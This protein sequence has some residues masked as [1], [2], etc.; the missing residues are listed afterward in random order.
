MKQ[1]LVLPLCAALLLGG[2]GQGRQD[3]GTARA[4]SVAQ[5]PP[6]E[7]AHPLAR[8]TVF[9]AHS[10]VFVEA[11]SLAVGEDARL[12]VHVTRLG[13]FSALGAAQVTLTLSGGGQP[14]EVF[15]PGDAPQPG[16]YPL[17]LRPAAG[18]LREL[19]IEV[20][21]ADFRERHTLGRI[22]VHSNHDA[23]AHDEDSHPEAGGE[24]I[25]FSK[26]RQW[27]SDFATIAVATRPLRTVLPATGTLRA[28]PDGEAWLTAPLAGQI[29]AGRN[30]PRLG[31][32]V[33]QGEIL[34]YLA[35]RLGGE[36]D[37]A[38]LRAALAR[39][40][41]EADLAERELARLEGLWADE[42]IP[43]KRVFAARAGAAAARA[44][45]EAAQARLGQYGGA[46]SGAPL[47][48]PVSGIIA[49][50]RSAPGAWAQE[51]A[52]LFHIADRRVLWLELRVAEADAARL[53]APDGAYFRIDGV[54][55]G[56]TVTPGK[57]ARLIAVGGAIDPLSRTLPVVFEF[58]A[59][60]ERLRI[61][62]AVKAEVFAGA[63]RAATAIP[64]TAVVDD[65]GAPTVYLMR[66]GEAFER[67][68]VRLG[69][70]AGEWVEVLD[71]L[72]PGQRVVA[73]GAWLVRLAAARGGDI[74]HGH[75]H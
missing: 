7:A 17:T 37:L 6:G 34:A 27:K 13:D 12:A 9:G 38:S 40:R 16:I 19:S 41:V 29:Q 14:D 26:E 36:T 69:I 52:P 55:Q 42:A 22:A 28:R 30:F 21:T 49:E 20:V 53:T 39:S 73:R 23:H 32:H 72:T 74:G 44:E 45:L 70:R 56:F 31:Q 65:N 57:E 8:Y 62:M 47:R 59:R 48:A 10:E 24:V 63:A 4:A 54:E 2:C 46:S 51:G 68:T 58:A 5:S 60:D 35:P 15:F 25:A 67:R 64:A 18:A 75:S 61:G 71:G 66:D 50:S 33:R 11:P 43:E 3:G 1:H